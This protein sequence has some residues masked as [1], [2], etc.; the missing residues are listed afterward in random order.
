MLE[1]VKTL[2][3]A[4]NPA[5]YGS[6]YLSDP[7]YALATGGSDRAWYWQCCTEFSYFQTWSFDH[8]M[9]SK[10]LTLSFWRKWCQDNYG[11]T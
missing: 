7:Q 11:D 5:N 6:Y 4:V 3:K 10:L 9:R 1:V 2:V 8:P